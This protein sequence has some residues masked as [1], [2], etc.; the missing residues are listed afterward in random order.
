MKNEENKEKITDTGKTR[1]NR[2]TGKKR[3]KQGKSRRNKEKKDNERI[4]ISFII[5]FFCCSVTKTSIKYYLTLITWLT[6]DL[7]ASK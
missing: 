1:I 4:M 6:P 7:N 3:G 5:I 2:K